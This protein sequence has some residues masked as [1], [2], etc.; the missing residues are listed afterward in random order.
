MAA[1]L[2]VVDMATFQAK[3]SAP[4]PPPSDPVYRLLETKECMTCHS[5]DG[6]EGIGPT[7]KGIFGRTTKLT[8]GSAV[9]ADG[10][11]GIDSQLAP[12]APHFPAK[13]KACI[14][15]FMYGGVSQV[16]TFDSK[17]ELTRFHGKPIPTLESDQVLKGRNPGVLL[18]SSRKF[19]RY[20]QA[21]TSVSDLFPHFARSVD[22]V[23]LIRSMYTDSF[24]HGSGLLQMNTGFVR[25]GYPSL[26]SWVTYGLGT[27]NSNLPGYVVLLDHRGGPISGPPTQREKTPGKPFASATSCAMICVA[28]A[29]KG[30]SGEGFQ[31][32]ES[33]QTAATAAFHAQTATGKLNAVM[34]PT[35]PSGCHCSNIR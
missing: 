30:A 26:G 18:G 24:A 23:A 12:K 6:S 7:F 15:L 1:N 2:R 4:S 35:G 21:G 14:V 34:T 10:G 13:A 27:V 3:Q 22:D 5:I 20:G 25:Q 19:A 9:A 32:V 16:D 33:P 29:V 28:R 17:P 8:N 11:L 31:S